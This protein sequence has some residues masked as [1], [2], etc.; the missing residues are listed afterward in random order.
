MKLK[1]K[2]HPEAN[3]NVVQVIE[4]IAVTEYSIVFGIHNETYS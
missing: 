2:D 4:I 1:A 3:G